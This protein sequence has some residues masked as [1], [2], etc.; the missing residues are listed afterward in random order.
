MPKE[1]VLIAAVTIDGFI[2]RN[3]LE[4]TSWSKDLHVFKKQT[5][6]FPVIMGF[7]TKKT[8]SEHLKGRE[9]IVINRGDSPKEVLK[10]IK[11]EKCF[12]IGGGKTNYLFAPFLT[13][14]YITPHPYVFGKGVFLFD[15]PLM[16]ELEVKFTTL[17][18]IDRKNGIFQYQYDVLRP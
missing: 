6:G 10:N 2:A 4:I 18:E 1:V 12:V 3:N 15:G 17:F 14:L 13:H 8:L 11:K 16:R 9:S 5:M 7:N